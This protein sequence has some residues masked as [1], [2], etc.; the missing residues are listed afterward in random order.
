[1]YEDLHQLNDA[2]IMASA[3]NFSFFNQVDTFRDNASLQWDFNAKRLEFGCS[4][5]QTA[6]CTS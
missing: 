1:M 2:I 5:F 6:R 3:E 4:R